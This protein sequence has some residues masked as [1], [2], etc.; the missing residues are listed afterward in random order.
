MTD[1]AIRVENC[2]LSRVE[3]LSK[4][5]RIGKSPHLFQRLHVLTFQR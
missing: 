5:Y 3:G 2:I 4:L 1:I